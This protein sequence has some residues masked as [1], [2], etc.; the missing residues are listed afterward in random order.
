MRI[1]EGRRRLAPTFF[2]APPT[3]LLLMDSSSR[4]L[5]TRRHTKRLPKIS[6]GKPS[7]FAPNVMMMLSFQKRFPP[8]ANLPGFGRDFAY[9]SRACYALVN[10]VKNQTGISNGKCKKKRLL[11]E[12]SLLM[13]HPIRCFLSFENRI[14]KGLRHL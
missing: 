8:L 1:V 6:L 9:C 10:S 14:S 4:P 7:P 5:S 3:S 11:I 12:V 13:D 2:L